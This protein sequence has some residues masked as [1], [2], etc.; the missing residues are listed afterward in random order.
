MIMKAKAHV[1]FL[2]QKLP[3]L[4]LK[5]SFSLNLKLKESHGLAD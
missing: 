3:T 5:Q 1:R 2:P 4:F